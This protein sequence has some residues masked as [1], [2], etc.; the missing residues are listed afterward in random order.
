MGETANPPVLALT[1]PHCDTER[2][3]FE[4][5]YCQRMYPGE[6]ASSGLSSVFNTMCVCPRCHNAIV[7]VIEANRHVVFE[8]PKFNIEDCNVLDVFPR[9]TELKVPDFTPPEV[10][11]IYLQGLDCLRRGHYDACEVMMRKTIEITA[12]IK[13]AKEN[14]LARKIQWLAKSNIITADMAAWA[15]E[16]R[17]AGNEAAHEDG[18]V[19]KAEASEIADFTELLLTYL[20]QLPGM[21]AK[22]RKTRMA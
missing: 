4:L 13:G 3:G 15:D 12:G 18:P 14:G 5:V 6:P 11:N 9:M 10:A 7:V 21:L 20:F 1:C 22:R 16:I 2:S 17:L 19:G 8:R